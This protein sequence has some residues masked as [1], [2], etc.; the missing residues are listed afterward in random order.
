LLFFSAEYP[1]KINA[2]S[3]K[4]S[5]KQRKFFLCSEKSSETHAPTHITTAKQFFIK[6]PISMYN[7]EKQRQKYPWSFTPLINALDYA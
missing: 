7:R 4:A 2:K 5:D 1:E 3:K 6:K